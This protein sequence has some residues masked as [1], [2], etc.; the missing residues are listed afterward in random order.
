[1][2][3]LD[4]GERSFCRTSGETGRLVSEKYSLVGVAGFLIGLGLLEMYFLTG[5]GDRDLGLKLEISF[6]GGK[7]LLRVV[8]GLSLKVT[9]LGLALLDLTSRLINFESLTGL[10][11]F[12]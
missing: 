3:F 2:I 10:V 5:L 8:V 9:D 12:K 6:F 11:C 7:L 4:D 1:M